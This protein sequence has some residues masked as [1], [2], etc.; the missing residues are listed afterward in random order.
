MTQCPPHSTQ[1]Y[2][3]RHT[4]LGGKGQIEINTH[5]LSFTEYTV[6]TT[7][8]YVLF[9]HVQTVTNVLFNISVSTSYTHSLFLSNA[10]TLFSNFQLPPPPVHIYTHTACV[11]HIHNAPHSTL[12]E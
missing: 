5:T 3:E 4:A 12:P 11:Q 10:Y 9:K 7:K 8:I 2:R 6:V 1:T